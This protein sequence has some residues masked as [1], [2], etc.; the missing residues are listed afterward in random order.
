VPGAKGGRHVRLTTSPPCGKCGSLDVSQSYGLRGL[1]ALPCTV[2]VQELTF[3][4]PG[5]HCKELRHRMHSSWLKREHNPWMDCVSLVVVII[6][7]VVVVVVAA[8]VVFGTLQRR[9][10][11]RYSTS[12]TVA[13]SSP[14]EVI[15]FLNSP[16]LCSRTVALTLFWLSHKQKWVIEDLCGGKGWP[17]LKTTAIF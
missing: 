16:N 14:D 1:L 15:N 3:P 4:C 5:R 7:V 13:G 8:I 10:L 17:A 6:I 11:T 2:S 9:W 12:P